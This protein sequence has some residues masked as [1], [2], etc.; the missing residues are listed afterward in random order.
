MEELNLA[1]HFLDLIVR[2]N[3]I[4]KKGSF[5]VFATQPRLSS[6]SR[7]LNNMYSLLNN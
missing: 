4:S 3:L 7:T 5:Y 2:N 1:K 6:Q